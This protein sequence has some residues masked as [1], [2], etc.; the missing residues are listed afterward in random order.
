MQLV[1][2]PTHSFLL[3]SLNSGPEGRRFKSSPR[4]IPSITC[5][6]GF[7]LGHPLVAEGFRLILFG[8]CFLFILSGSGNRFYRS[9]DSVHSLFPPALAVNVLGHVDICVAHVVPDDLRPCTLVQH[10][11]G[12]HRAEAPKI[13]GTGEAQLGSGGLDVAQ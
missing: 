8:F 13:H 10:E 6:L 3:R 4:P 7:L 2:T 1:L 12:V 9:S 11:P 5:N